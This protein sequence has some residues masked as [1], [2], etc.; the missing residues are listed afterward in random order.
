MSMPESLM[1][2]GR[3]DFDESAER[4]KHDALKC[5]DTARDLI[6]SE[7]WYV[8]LEVLFDSIQDISH[9]RAMRPRSEAY[10]QCISW[11]EDE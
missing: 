2:K 7:S 4:A 11:K 5:I 10:A 1:R 8:A 3:R 6:K 9:A